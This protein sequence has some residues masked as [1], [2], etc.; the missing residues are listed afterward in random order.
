MARPD[1]KDEEVIGVERCVDRRVYRICARNLRVGVFVAERRGFVGVRQK[2]HPS[3]LYLATEYHRDNGPPYGTACPLE[4][5]GPLPD[6]IRAEEHH[7]TVCHNCGTAAKYDTTKPRTDGGN[8]LPGTWV[9]LGPTDCTD[10]RPVRANNDALFRHLKEV[11]TRLGLTWP[12]VEEYEEAHR[13]YLEEL[14]AEQEDG[15]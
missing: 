6:E 2:G 1:F 10:L 5:L 13:Q 11:E 14:E 3:N 12:S 9:H 15:G 4:D 8:P 7:G